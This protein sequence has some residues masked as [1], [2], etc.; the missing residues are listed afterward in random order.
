[1]TGKVRFPVSV[2]WSIWN[3]CRVVTVKVGRTVI[4][5]TAR[6]RRRS[7]QWT[8]CLAA[9]ENVS[10]VQLALGD[11]AAADNTTPMQSGVLRLTAGVEV[12][13]TCTVTGGMPPPSVEL[14]LNGLNI[15]DQVRRNSQSDVHA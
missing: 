8:T 14:F 3:R 2:P 10:S 7:L 4:L 15:T 11:A 12:A 9:A 13:L 1:M 5:K 6:R